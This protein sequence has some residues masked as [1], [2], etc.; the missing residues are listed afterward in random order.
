MMGGGA[1]RES[2][3]EAHR[4]AGGIGVEFE[5]R[6]KAKNASLEVNR[7][8]VLDTEVFKHIA[9]EMIQEVGVVPLLHTQVVDAILDGDTIRGVVTKSKSG[10]GAI[11]ARRVIDATGDAD[12]AARAGVPFRIDPEVELEPV[13]VNFGCS[14][15]DLP[16]LVPYMK[17]HPSSVADWGDRSGEKETAELTTFLR[18]PFDLAKQPARSPRTCAWRAT[19]EASPTPGRSRASTPSTSRGSTRPTCGT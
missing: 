9:D 18:K 8:Q 5:R 16:A 15:V 6:A 13:T 14:G 12:V 1:T 3:D 11:L 4:R 7:Y 17:E 2:G 10:R 19:G